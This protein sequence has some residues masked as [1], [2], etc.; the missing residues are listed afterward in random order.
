MKDRL[1]PLCSWNN[2]Y[3]IIHLIKFTEIALIKHY[4]N[5]KLPCL[6]T[7]INGHTCCGWRN[8]LQK[9]NLT[10]IFCLKKWLT[11]FVSTLNLLAKLDLELGGL[12]MPFMIY[13]SFTNTSGLANLHFIETF[14]MPLV[15]TTMSKGI[16]SKLFYRK[17]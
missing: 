5:M 15:E 8:G 12:N 11:S 2:S 6:C 16:F 4:T 7:L 10:I 9:F 3:E 13:M 17:N 1:V 14:V